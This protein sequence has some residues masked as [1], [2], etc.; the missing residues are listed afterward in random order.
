MENGKQENG[1]ET[2]FCG[3]SAKKDRIV[4]LT[5]SKYL[6]TADELI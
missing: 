6:P 5:L 2:N 4:L 3:L 1:Q